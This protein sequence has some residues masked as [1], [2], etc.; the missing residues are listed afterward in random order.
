MEE[1][2]INSAKLF[3]HERIAAIAE[4]SVCMFTRI[5]KCFFLD[6]FFRVFILCPL[7]FLLRGGRLWHLSSK[8]KINQADFTDR[9]SLRPSTLHRKSAPIQTLSLQ[10]SK[11]FHQQGITKKTNNFYINSLIY[12]IV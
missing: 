11:A 12:P 6:N 7:L 8:S 3:Y 4:I 9:M 5:L 1:N 10:I 2:D